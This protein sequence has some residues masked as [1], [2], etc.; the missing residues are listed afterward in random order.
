[1]MLWW[2]EGN[3]VEL[4][5]FPF[6]LSQVS[7]ASCGMALP[8]NSNRGRFCPFVQAPPIIVRYVTHLR[9][10][11]YAYPE[12]ALLDMLSYN[13]SRITPIKADNLNGYFIVYQ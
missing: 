12:R 6:A 10:N 1:M 13:Y 4:R 11:P 2:P 5:N 8:R 7:S 9:R 3:I